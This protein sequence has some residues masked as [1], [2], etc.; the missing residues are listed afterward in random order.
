MTETATDRSHLDV[1]LTDSSLYANGFP[2]EVF[3]SL[4][5]HAPV[6]WQSFPEAFKG[7]HDE[8]FWVLSKHEDVQTASHNPEIFE[9]VRRTSVESPTRHCRDD[10]RQYGRS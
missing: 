3:T 2:H 6:K 5:R 1:D 7:G 8:G 4:R 9:R 10:A